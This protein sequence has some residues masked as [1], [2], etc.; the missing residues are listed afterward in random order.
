MFESIF[1]ATYEAI[2][3]DAQAVRRLLEH[4]AHA[5]LEARLVDARHQ[6]AVEAA[7]QPFLESGDLARRGVGTQHHLLAV[8]MQRIEGEELF[9]QRSCWAMS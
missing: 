7:G 3:G 9:L 2:V 8:L 6:A 5:C 1:A 4:D